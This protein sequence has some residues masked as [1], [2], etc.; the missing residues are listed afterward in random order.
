[1]GWFSRM[2][3]ALLL[4]ASALLIA[5]GI[6][7]QDVGGTIFGRVGDESGKAL[8]GATVTARNVNTGVARVAPTDAAGLYRLVALPVGSY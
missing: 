2:R 7:A 4:V 3:G 5:S 1:M 6:A 8:P